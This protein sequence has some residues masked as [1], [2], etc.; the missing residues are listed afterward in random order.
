MACNMMEFVFLQQ[1]QFK[2]KRQKEDVPA[3]DLK[4]WIDTVGTQLE[5]WVGKDIA[6]L[7]D[8][9]F[10][11]FCRAKQKVLYSSGLSAV[12]SLVQQCSSNA[13]NLSFSEASKQQLLLKIPKSHRLRP[14]VG[15]FLEAWQ[16]AAVFIWNCYQLQH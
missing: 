5:K 4:L 3:S 11:A 8:T 1:E 6:N 7:V 14:L 10:V 13:A 12:L 15:A 16:H 9:S 2:E